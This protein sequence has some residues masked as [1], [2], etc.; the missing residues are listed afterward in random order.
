ML[1]RLNNCWRFPQHETFFMF[2]ILQIISH[3]L[4][5]K[6]AWVIK[7]LYGNFALKFLRLYKGC[8][9]N[10]K[11]APMLHVR[12]LWYANQ[13][14]NDI[15]CTSASADCV[16]LSPLKSLLWAPICVPGFEYALGPACCKKSL[17]ICQSGWKEIKNVLPVIRWVG[18][19]PD[20]GADVTSRGYI[21]RGGGGYSWK[22]LVGAWHPVHQI[23]TLFQTKKGLF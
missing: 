22:F 10:P 8:L 3:C 2:R 21:L 20:V 12:I 18:W 1:R 6:M 19:E 11:D 9:H 13:L 14:R 16:P 15:K 5:L 4:F 7:D 17:W 23:L